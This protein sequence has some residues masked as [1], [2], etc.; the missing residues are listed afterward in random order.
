VRG[1]GKQRRERKKGKT[2]QQKKNSVK[3]INRER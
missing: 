1:E 2:K 3:E